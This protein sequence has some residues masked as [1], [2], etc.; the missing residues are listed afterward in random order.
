M[1][2]LAASSAEIA[3]DGADL[4]VIA[5]SPLDTLDLLRALAGPWHRSL[6]PD[7][8][9]TD[10]AS[11]KASIVALAGELGLRFVGGH[12]LAGRET[13]G[14]KAADPDLFRDRPW[15]LV[16]SAD[17]AAI[18]RVESLVG[19]CGAVPIRMPAEEHDRVVAAISHLPL[20]LSAALVEAV[21][22]GPGVAR[23]GWSAA[24]GLAAGGWDS[25][26][27]LAR[28]DVEMGTGIAATNAREIAVRLRD[29]REV[30]DAWLADLEGPDADAIRTRLAAARA[31]L[32]DDS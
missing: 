12:P 20:V 8:V 4:V 7:A 19:L 5:A 32:V 16:P 2:E 22:G 23:P 25:M 15:V 13:A 10:V 18:S 21:A 1:I 28:G 30:I 9:I 14:F 31:V 6:A 3:I 11:T 17:T 29:V 24:S 26:T 27:R